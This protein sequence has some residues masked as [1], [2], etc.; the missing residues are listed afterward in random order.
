MDGRANSQFRRNSQLFCSLFTRVFRII[1][2]LQI[3]DYLQHFIT[4]LSLYFT[5]HL[6]LLFPLSPLLQPPLHRHL[7]NPPFLDKIHS[8]SH[9]RTIFLRPFGPKIQS[10]HPHFPLAFIFLRKE[11]DQFSGGVFRWVRVGGGSEALD[12][13]RGWEDGE[14][15]TAFFLQDGEEIACPGE[16]A[17]VDDVVD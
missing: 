6:F 2:S 1:I 4:S 5:L 12:P 8:T 16:G 14:F 11:S 9:R 17:G 7:H 15:E 13:F 3:Q 10:L